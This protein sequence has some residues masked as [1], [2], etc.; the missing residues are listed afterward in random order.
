MFWMLHRLDDDVCVYTYVVFVAN[1]ED[2]LLFL[3]LIQLCYQ[4]LNTKYSEVGNITTVCTTYTVVSVCMC[5]GWVKD[6]FHTYFWM[7]HK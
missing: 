5:C 6:Y 1:T 3:R 7:G 4:P 2:I